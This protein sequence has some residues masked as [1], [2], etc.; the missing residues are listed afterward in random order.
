MKIENLIKANSFSY[1][2]NNYNDF[3]NKILM[4]DVESIT[5]EITHKNLS[6]NLAIFDNNNEEKENRFNLIRNNIQKS[7][8]ELIDVVKLE[9]EQLDNK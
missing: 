2:I 4:D 1:E 5:I 8:S 7:F 6:K 3:R 9:Y